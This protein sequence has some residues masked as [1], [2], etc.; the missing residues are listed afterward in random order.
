MIL[1]GVQRQP[2]SKWDRIALPPKQIIT[3]APK[4]KAERGN[5]LWDTSLPRKR[6][7]TTEGADIRTEAA[8]KIKL[9]FPIF[10]R[11]PKLLFVNLYPR[12]V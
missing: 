1:N 5:F 9:E 11:S 7:K 3:N 12:K 10:N 2:M 8:L 4:R 6:Q